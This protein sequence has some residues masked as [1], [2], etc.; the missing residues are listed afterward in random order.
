MRLNKL[1]GKKVITVNDLIKISDSNE[2]KHS[3]KLALESVMEEYRNFT[4]ILI[5]AECKDDA[6]VTHRAGF[7]NSEI[8]YVA[9]LTKARMLQEDLLGI[10]DY[11]CED[12]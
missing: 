7:T 10:D 12:D 1:P 6:I 11:D 3:V 2:A 4:K 9:E 5:I 8:V